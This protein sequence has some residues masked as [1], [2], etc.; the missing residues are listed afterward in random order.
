MQ[1]RKWFSRWFIKSREPDAGAAFIAPDGAV[2]RFVFEPRKLYSADGKPKP[3]AFEPER[4]PEL[5]R[6]ETSICGLVGVPQR[7]V[8]YL[9][10]TIRPGLRALAIIE[11]PVSVVVAAGLQCEAAPEENYPEHGVIIGWDEDSKSHRMSVC[12]DL[13]SGASNVR[14]LVS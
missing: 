1:F 14:K 10:E 3:H 13:A 5:R 2:G 4:H 6:F 11:L 12:Q 8:S 7:R 9:G